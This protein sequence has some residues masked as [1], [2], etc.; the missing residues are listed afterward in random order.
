MEACRAAM[1]GMAGIPAGSGEK[2]EGRAAVR[3]VGGR[4]DVPRRVDTAAAT[5]EAATAGAEA[6]VGGLVGEA[7]AARR[8]RRLARLRRP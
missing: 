5:A 8:V 1:V 6:T 2:E 7:R 4:A 3:A